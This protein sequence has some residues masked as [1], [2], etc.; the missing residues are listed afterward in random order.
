MLKKVNECLKDLS[1]VKQ[2]ASVSDTFVRSLD[3]HLLN[4]F[5]GLP[6]LEY[7]YTFGNETIIEEREI[8][9]HRNDKHTRYIQSLEWKFA[10]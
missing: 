4:D 8:K 9:A 1:S 7:I 10:T 2:K 5:I 3:D 6:H